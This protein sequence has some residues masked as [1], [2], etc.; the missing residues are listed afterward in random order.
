ML[1]LE[2]LAY[3]TDCMLFCFHFYVA[4]NSFPSQHPKENNIPSP[5]LEGNET[6]HQSITPKDLTFF[7]ILLLF[8]FGDKGNPQ[9]LSFGCAQGKTH[10][11][12]Q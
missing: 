9:P 11:P 1:V 7:M 4:G 2:I 8:F 10:A 5:I 12:M 6:K 3:A